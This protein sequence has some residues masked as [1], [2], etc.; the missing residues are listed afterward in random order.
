MASLNYVL[1]FNDI[2]FSQIHV[3]MGG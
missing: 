1:M 2:V 3:H